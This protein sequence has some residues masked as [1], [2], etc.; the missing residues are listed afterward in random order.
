MEREIWSEQWRL[1]VLNRADLARA[2]L[3]SLIIGFV[4][5]L[6]HYQGN[7]LDV[8]VFGRSALAWMVE[9]WTDD[10]EYGGDY[11]HGWLIPILS[12]YVV[13]TRRKELAAAPK[14]ISYTGL[15]L[16]VACLLLHWLGAKAQQTRLS[17]F[18]LVG[19][20]WTIPYYF[21]GWQVAKRLIFPCAYLIFCIPFNFLDS[22]THPLR[23]FATSVAT[24]LLNGVGIGVEQSGARLH[25]LSPG[26]FDLDVADA[27]SGIRSLIAITAL[28]AIYANLTQRTAWRQWLM[29]FMSIPLA[30]VGNVVRIFTTGIVAEAFGTDMAM[31][32]YHDF[33]GFIIFMVVFILLI[34]V[35]SLMERS[36]Y[37]EKKRWWLGHL[38]T[39]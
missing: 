19:L 28:T 17:L 32:M 20:T 14:A 38:R 5:F 33:S 23:I 30:L 8:R 15:S 21:Y 3:I 16:V 24:F 25:S 27:C 2:V 29:F 7:T 10:I 9:R 22:V 34:S 12:L 1:A 6:F 11:S 39:T 37:E 36:W 26:G 18:A 35:G 13:W 31:Q 4:F